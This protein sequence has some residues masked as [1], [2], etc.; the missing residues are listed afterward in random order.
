MKIAF[1]TILSILVFC[2]PA[3]ASDTDSNFCR[4]MNEQYLCH[5]LCRHEKGI[6]FNKTDRLVALLNQELKFNR[7]THTIRFESL[8]HHTVAIRIQTT[9][10]ARWVFSKEA[11]AAFFELVQSLKQTVR[12]GAAVIDPELKVESEVIFSL[13]TPQLASWKILSAARY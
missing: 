13:S 12:Y 4:Q 9:P 5:Q 10:Q 3:V 8:S 1:K 6:Q 7:E 11:I 2:L